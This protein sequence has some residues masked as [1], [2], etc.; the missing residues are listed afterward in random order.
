MESAYIS[1]KILTELAY[2]ISKSEINN[3]SLD[4]KN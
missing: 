4:I 1:S 3:P 2:E